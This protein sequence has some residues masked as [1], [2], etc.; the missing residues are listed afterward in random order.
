MRCRC[1][2]CREIELADF[3]VKAGFWFEEVTR[4][5]AACVHCNKPDC[6]GAISCETYHCPSMGSAMYRATD[7]VPSPYPMTTPED[8][9]MT[10]HP[11]ATPGVPRCPL[12]GILLDLE[13]D[14]RTYERDKMAL[15]TLT[16]KSRD[17]VTSPHT[18]NFP[19]DDQR[20]PRGASTL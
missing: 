16:P 17:H 3:S 1:A 7:R 14:I 4:R 19:E 6:P 9:T 2:R 8:L 15:L 5:R 18:M 11:Q 12:C 13:T 20:S 10:R